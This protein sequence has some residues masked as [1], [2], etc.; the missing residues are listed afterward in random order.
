MKTKILLFLALASASFASQPERI[1][2]VKTGEIAKV[3]A[4]L[5]AGWTV[6]AQSSTLENGRRLTD[7]AIHVFTLVPPAPSYEAAQAAQK[8][9]DFAKRRAEYLAKKNA[10]EALEK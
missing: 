2:I 5:D 6:K 3:Q 4:M 1:V 9:E 10:S 7:N 8:A